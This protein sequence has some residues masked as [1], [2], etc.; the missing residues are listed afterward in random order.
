MG[1]NEQL[2]EQLKEVQESK[3]SL[4]EELRGTAAKIDNKL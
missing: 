2:V 3:V 4:I 1:Q